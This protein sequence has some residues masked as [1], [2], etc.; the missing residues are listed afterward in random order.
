M[1]TCG[2]V[3][4]FHARVNRIYQVI[5]TKRHKTK[6]IVHRWVWPHFKP[7]FIPRLNFLPPFF[8]SRRLTAA[9]CVFFVSLFCFGFY[10]LPLL[11][12]YSATYVHSAFFSPLLMIDTHAIQSYRWE[13]LN[14]PISVQYGPAHKPAG[15]S[16]IAL[17]LCVCM[18][19]C[20]LCVPWTQPS[21]IDNRVKR[22]NRP[23]KKNLN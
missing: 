2:S 21:Y 12:L 11:L 20:V 16:P 15:L 3:C 23:K 18:C 9:S 5:G 4:C 7:N 8:R 13:S 19:V 14:R 10:P 1:F 17:A 22:C 6:W